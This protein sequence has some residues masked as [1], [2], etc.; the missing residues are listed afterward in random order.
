[1]PWTKGHRCPSAPLTPV[2]YRPT[3]HWPPASPLRRPL[4]WPT[5]RCASYYPLLIRTIN[6]LRGVTLPLTA[7]GTGLVDLLLARRLIGAVDREWPAYTVKLE[8]VG[9]GVGLN[10]VQ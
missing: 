7:S 2:H 6:G 3:S 9:F 8:V 10:D 1:M 5:K 4:P